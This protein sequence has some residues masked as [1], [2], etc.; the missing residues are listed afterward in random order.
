MRHDLQCKRAPLIESSVRFVRASS[1]STE[2]T[3]T[4]K[5]ARKAAK[6]REKANKAAEC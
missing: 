4:E 6:E 5:Q 1:C 2:T 3:N